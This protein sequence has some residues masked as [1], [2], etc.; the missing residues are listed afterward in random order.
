M[1]KFFKILD[2]FFTVCNLIVKFLCKNSFLVIGIIIV[3]TIS[4]IVLMFNKQINVGGLLG[5]LLGKK[6]DFETIN[7]IPSNRKQALEEA[8][9]Y[10][11]IQH[12]IFEF[13]KSLNPFRDKTVI[14][15]PDR[16]KVKLPEGLKDTDI[17]MIIQNKITIQIIPTEQSYKKALEIQD[18]LKKSDQ[19][20]NTASEL[21]A[22]LKERQ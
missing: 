16:T 11:Y 5:W 14:I 8:D 22:K 19:I 10:G 6:N 21:L 3:I 12:R 7:S 4:I 13:T 15:L 17:D 20:N 1:E 9:K 2:S 18:L